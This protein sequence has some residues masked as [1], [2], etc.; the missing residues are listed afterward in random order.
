MNSQVEHKLEHNVLH[1]DMFLHSWVI[2]MSSSVSDI[3][4]GDGSWCS[5]LTT[6]SY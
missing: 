1:F 2:C 6:R 5:V 4:Y 3:A